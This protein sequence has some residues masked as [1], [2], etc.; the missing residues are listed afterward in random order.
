MNKEIEKNLNVD[1]EL[2]DLKDKYAKLKY[3]FFNFATYN[4]HAS[5]VNG[6]LTLKEFF[7]NDKCVQN[8][9]KSTCDE[10]GDVGY[11]SSVHVI[12]TI[13]K[14]LDCIEERKDIMDNIELSKD[15]LIHLLK[16][17]ISDNAILKKEIT[18]LHEECNGY[19]IRW[20]DF[21]VNNNVSSVNAWL[22]MEEFFNTD[23][24]IQKYYKDTCEELIHDQC[25]GKV[26][27]MITTIKK[28]LDYISE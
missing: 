15:E 12:K 25:Y 20:N 19:V 24:E 4:H 5:S 18:K 10:I 7:E 22:K 3:S 28:L 8:Y 21:Q 14:L 26:T 17:E 9:Y 13:E 23:M 6:W 1:K 2:T 16:K 11:M 27:H